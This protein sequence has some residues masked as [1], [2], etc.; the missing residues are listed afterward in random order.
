M[1]LLYHE[2]MAGQETSGGSIPA[3][4]WEKVGSSHSFFFFFFF[5]DIYVWTRV[6]LTW[7]ILPFLL[8]LFWRPSSLSTRST[9]HRRTRRP[10]WTKND[11]SFGYSNAKQTTLTLPYLRT[12]YSIYPPQSL[13]A[14]VI[15]LETSLLWSSNIV[16]AQNLPNKKRHGSINLLR[17]V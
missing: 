1:R 6:L 13:Q 17:L 12:L 11:P 16:Y 5:W 14:L 7:R 3:G 4:G 9:P 8:L 2:E 10:L 15:D